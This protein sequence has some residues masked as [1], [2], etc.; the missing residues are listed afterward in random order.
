MTSQITAVLCRPTTCAIACLAASILLTAAT[1]TALAQDAPFETSGDAGLT[2][3][4]PRE[5]ADEATPGE[6]P[7]PS[8][9]TLGTAI[10]PAS[11]H[12]V[13]VDAAARKL[14]AAKTDDEKRSAKAELR[15]AL[16][17]IFALDMKARRAQADQI[18]ARLAKLREQYQAREKAKDEIIDRRLQ[19]IEQDAAGLGFPGTGKSTSIEPN[20]GPMIG[21]AF[22]P[23]DVALDEHLQKYGASAQKHIAQLARAGH[24]ARSDDGKLYAYVEN[25]ADGAEQT[26]QIRVCMAYSG[27]RIVAADVEMPVGK[28]KFLKQGVATLDADGKPTMRVEFTV[29]WPAPAASTIP[30]E[31]FRSSSAPARTVSA[32]APS[33]ASA[34]TD[35]NELRRQ[36]VRAQTS[37]DALK[38]PESRD[39]A[40]TKSALAEVN[41][42]IDS[43]L[44]LLRLDIQAAEIALR[45]AESKW[46]AI[47]TEFKVGNVT[48][49]EAHKYHAARDTAQLDLERAKTIYD[50]FNSIK[51][52]PP[53][54]ANPYGG[55]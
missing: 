38:D 6:L 50:L 10:A 32:V 28:L 37:L 34:I 35:Y 7:Q 2:P 55:R 29:H 4:L 14:R 23:L 5:L 15:K 12:Q 39:A 18:E 43:K 40:R 45:A 49:S 48:E 25:N 52:T 26:A 31:T 24:F 1:E 17:Q 42:L 22:N 33:R 30:Y 51:D 19:S 36:Y 41:R 53:A 44:H 54:A 47:D 16:A 20:D 46:K 21:A 3:P 11:S 13:E 27:Q 8:D 9:P